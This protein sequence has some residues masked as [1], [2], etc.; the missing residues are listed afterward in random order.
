M[1]RR[2]TSNLRR[3]LVD[4]MRRGTLNVVKIRTKG[5]VVIVKD[6][7]VRTVDAGLELEALR[8]GD[9]A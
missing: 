7:K 5:V 8:D 4:D 2:V 6:V 1:N 3:L 9:T